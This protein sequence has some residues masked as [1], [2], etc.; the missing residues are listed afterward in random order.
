MRYYLYRDIE[1]LKEIY[2]QFVNLN[3]DLDVIERIDAKSCSQEEGIFTE[4]ETKIDG[5]C[6]MRVKIGARTANSSNI[7]T[8]SEYANI[9]DV[10]DIHNKR[11]YHNLIENLRKDKKFPQGICVECG[12]IN[13]LRN[14]HDGLDKFIEINGSYIWFENDKMS[15]DIHILSTITNNIEVIGCVIKDKDNLSPKVIKAIAMYIDM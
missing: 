11:F 14:E 3:L 7:T 2:S 12:K 5:K 6:D 10:K 13:C 9:E 8:I 4:P 15:N 1:L